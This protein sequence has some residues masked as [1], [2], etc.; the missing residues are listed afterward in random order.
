MT[1]AKMIIKS[2][3]YHSDDNYKQQVTINWWLLQQW[4]TADNHIGGHQQHSTI[5]EAGQ[6][7]QHQ[8]DI[9]E[10]AEQGMDAVPWKQLSTA[11]A[12][13]HNGNGVIRSGVSYSEEW[14]STVVIIRGKH[15]EGIRGEWMMATVNPQKSKQLSTQHLYFSRKQFYQNKKFHLFNRFF[16][17]V[18][19]RSVFCLLWF[20]PFQ[21]SWMNSIEGGL[22][23]VQGF[24]TSMHHRWHSFI[25]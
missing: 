2:N 24:W 9:A 4:T 14:Q 19:T 16:Q 3:I 17:C 18:T 6:S 7:Q 5:S 25:Y 21:S 23:K 1:E 20:F 8:C 10:M 22:N 13:Q 15:K 11:V 12:T